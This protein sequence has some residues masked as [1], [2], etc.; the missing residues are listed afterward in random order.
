MTKLDT[1]FCCGWAGTYPI[2][3][4]VE[5]N[6]YEEAEAIALDRLQKVHPHGD[7]SINAIQRLDGPPDTYPAS[8]QA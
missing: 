4:A 7:L 1:Y 3:T 8:P 6:S 5:S 2:A